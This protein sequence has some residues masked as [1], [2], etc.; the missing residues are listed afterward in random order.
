MDER[1]QIKSK[2]DQASRARRLS[3]EL[4]QRADRDK[5]LAVGARLDAE[6]EALERK[7]AAPEP[8][9]T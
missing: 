3:L 9:N 1:Q 2:R 4:S 7:L 6:A 5:M 8:D